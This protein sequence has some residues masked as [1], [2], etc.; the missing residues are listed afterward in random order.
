MVRMFTYGVKIVVQVNNGYDSDI[1][2]PFQ[3]MFKNISVLRHFIGSYI[4]IYIFG[5]VGRLIYR[6]RF[7]K[8]T[9]P[10]NAEK[11]FYD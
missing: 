11:Y 4:Y 6:E 9:M 3:A 10:V 1:L 5:S 8:S 2:Y 7:N